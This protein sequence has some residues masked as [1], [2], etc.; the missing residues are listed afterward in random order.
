MRADEIMQVLRLTAMGRVGHPDQQR[1]CE[2]LEQMLQL[3]EFAQYLDGRLIEVERAVKAAPA[4]VTLPDVPSIVTTDGLHIPGAVNNPKR[5][6]KQ[7][8]E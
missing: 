2:A 4:C 5:T 3:M 1:L 8:A 6:R 7:K